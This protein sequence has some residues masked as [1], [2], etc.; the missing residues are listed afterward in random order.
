MCNYA[1][2]RFTIVYAMPGRG[3]SPFLTI[4]RQMWVLRKAAFACL[5][6]RSRR[7]R[8]NRYNIHGTYTRKDGARIHRWLTSGLEAHIRGDVLITYHQYPDI[9]LSHDLLLFIISTFFIYNSCLSLK[10]SMSS[11][12]FQES[13]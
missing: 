6:C 9:I 3:V 4:T 8:H 1:W 11:E 10:I 12:I 5:V 13:F 2:R 7:R